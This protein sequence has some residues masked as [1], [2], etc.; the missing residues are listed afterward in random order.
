M[1]YQWCGNYYIIK[2]NQAYLWLWSFGDCYFWVNL[3]RKQKKC[4]A[5]YGG[6]YHLKELCGRSSR[7]IWGY[8]PWGDSW[9]VGGWMMKKKK[10]A[11]FFSFLIIHQLGSQVGTWSESPSHRMGSRIRPNVRV[12]E[13]SHSGVTYVIHTKMIP[14]FVLPMAGC[15]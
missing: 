9:W 6:L 2:T 3:Q 12:I 7:Q 11:L 4:Q 8:L 14:S 13:W 10:K 15:R 1:E 5:G